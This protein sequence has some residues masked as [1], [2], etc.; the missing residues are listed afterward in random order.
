MYSKYFKCEIFNY[1]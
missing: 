1:M